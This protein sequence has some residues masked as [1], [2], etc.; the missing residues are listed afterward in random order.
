MVESQF[1]GFFLQT[2]LLHVILKELSISAGEVNV[3]GKIAYAAQ[4]PWLFSGT[5]RQNILFGKDFSPVWYKQ[6]VEACALV[7]DFELFPRGDASFVG[8]RGNMLSGGQK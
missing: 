3:N 7:H 1:H 4:E 2:S 6:V 8:E 5:V